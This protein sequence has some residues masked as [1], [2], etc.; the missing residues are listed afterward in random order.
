MILVMVRVKSGELK[1]HDAEEQEAQNS[2]Q[3]H[4]AY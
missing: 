4:L 2:R 3:A 1:Q